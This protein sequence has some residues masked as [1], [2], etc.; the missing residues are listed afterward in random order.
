MLYYTALL[1]RF[2]SPLSYEEVCWAATQTGPGGGSRAAGA[3]RRKHAP[4]AS[5]PA[6]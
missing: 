6:L 2:V 5:V 4:A 3:G 1:A